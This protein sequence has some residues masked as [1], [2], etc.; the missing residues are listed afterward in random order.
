MLREN[1]KAAISRSGMIVKEIAEKSGVKKRTIDKWVGA[2]ATEPKVN[3]LYKVCQTLGITIEWA[4]TGK[5]NCGFSQET[6][7]IANKISSLPP[8]DREEIIL[9]V[10]HKLSNNPKINKKLLC[11]DAGE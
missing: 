1:L 7:F 4:V 5:E 8:Q 10:N 9:L 6:I 2:E 3:D 11:K